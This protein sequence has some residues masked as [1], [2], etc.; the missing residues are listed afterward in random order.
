LENGVRG[1]RRKGKNGVNETNGNDESAY[2]PKAQNVTRIA[3][4]RFEISEVEVCTEK[5]TG[6]RGRK[7]NLT[8]DER[9]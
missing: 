7:K 6:R 4:L 2:Y 9:G 8:T 5:C 3:G 1:N